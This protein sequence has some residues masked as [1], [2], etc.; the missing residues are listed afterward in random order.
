MT[1]ME[2]HAL[3]EDKRAS[4]DTWLASVFGDNWRTEQLL[5]Q[6]NIVSEGIVLFH[7]FVVLGNGE[8]LTESEQRRT[9]TPPP[10]P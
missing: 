5:F 9:D 1:N 10:L 6:Y 8:L 3:T 2:Y 7:R 4:V